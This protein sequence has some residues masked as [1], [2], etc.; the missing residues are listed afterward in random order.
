MTL[1][2]EFKN[3]NSSISLLEP[4]LTGKEHRLELP[5]T[6]GDVHVLGAVEEGLYYCGIESGVEHGIVHIAGDDQTVT[7]IVGTTN[8]EVTGE[9]AH[10][11]VVDN[12][13]SVSIDNRAATGTVLFSRIS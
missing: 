4:G 5:S 2:G 13:T 3:P 11:A 8:F 12:G 6:S 9:A 1:A 7:K 10:L